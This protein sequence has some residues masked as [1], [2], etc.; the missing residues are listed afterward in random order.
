[1]KIGNYIHKGVT[2]NQLITAHNMAVECRTLR[3]KWNMSRG[4]TD[5]VRGW[6]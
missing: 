6:Y 1:M 4:E 3:S 2:S 5:A